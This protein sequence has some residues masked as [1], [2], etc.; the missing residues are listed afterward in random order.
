[1][2]KIIGRPFDIRPV[3]KINPTATLTYILSLTPETRTETQIKEAAEILQNNSFLIRYKNTKEL[4]ELVRR[5]EIKS[6]SMSE[7]IINQHEDMSFY[8]VIS[9][10]I[11]LYKKNGN[12][13]R[14]R[15]LVPWNSFNE[16]ALLSNQP[17]Q[18][19]V[20]AVEPSE[21]AVLTKEA[22]DAILKSSKAIQVHNAYFFLKNLPLMH[23]M[24][25]EF[26]NCFSELAYLKYFAPNTI[27]V[28]QNQVPNGIYIIV[29]GSVKV[30]RT[31]LFDS[32]LNLYKKIIIDEMNIGDIFCD[33]SYFNKASMHHTIVCNI[34]LTTY[35]LNKDDLNNVSPSFL[36]EFKRISR[37]YP[38]DNILKAMY[39]EKYSWNSYKS[40]MI[41]AVALEKEMQE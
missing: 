12:S 24:S 20:T 18:A 35:Y 25:E 8:I 33:Y 31:I 6:Y 37:G 2:S 27:V 38:D 19:V 34:P 40:N 17:I 23:G 29:Q 14:V 10:R 9:G 28:Q 21:L 5:M 13:N 32:K 26:L 22:Y 7:D 41:K 16:Q 30:I 3:K 1:M 15:E 39:V 4:Y 36:Y 11:S